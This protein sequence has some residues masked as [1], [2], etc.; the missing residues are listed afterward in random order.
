MSDKRFDIKIS[1]SLNNNLNIFKY[2]GLWDPSKKKWQTYIYRLYS[3]II[4]TTFFYLYTLSYMTDVIMSVGD[5]EK[6]S[7][8]SFLLLTLLA[9]IAK[10]L[11]IQIKQQKLQKLLDDLDGEIFKAKTEKHLEMIKKKMNLIKY[12][13]IIFMCM[14]EGTVTLWAIFPLFDK[15]NKI[16]LPLSGY[17]PYDYE[18]SPGFE[19]TYLYQIIG[20]VYLACLNCSLDIFISGIMVNATAQLDV[21]LDKFE[22][23]TGKEKDLEELENDEILNEIERNTNFLKS[24]AIHYEVIIRLNKYYLSNSNRN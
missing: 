8:G 18:N 21:L 6:F 3:V 7:K 23:G 24:C 19:L 22:F 14:Y 13:F 12:M 16:S 15:T 20:C 9:E 4:V 10:A 2:F 5:L 1:H 11:P 17:Y